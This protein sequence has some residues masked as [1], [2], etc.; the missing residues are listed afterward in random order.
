M[1]RV[2]IAFSG[3]VDST[4]LLAAACET[5]GKENILVITAT[6]P[7]YARRERSFAT[8]FT[9]KL[10]VAHV[11]VST[12]NL[13]EKGPYLNEPHRCYSCKAELFK[14]ALKVAREKGFSTV[15]EGTNASDV[16]DYRPGLKALKELGIRSPLMEAG[17]EKSE[18]RTLSKRMGL[19]TWDQPAMACLASRFPYGAEIT[20]EV[21]RQVECAEEVLMDAGY[22]QVRVRHHGDVAR[23]E[24]APADV[25]RLAANPG[26]VV[27]K[28]KALGFRYVTLD[29]QGYRTGAMNEALSPEARVR[30]SVA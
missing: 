2:A 20:P 11:F 8:D 26:D 13:E 10:G 12:W 23:I 14:E 3:G 30:G 25:V 21:L 4:F 9:A 15:I 5:L 24:L 27:A 7:V 1:G 28:L 19:P 18:I 16:H 22:R 17:L 6:G 29:L